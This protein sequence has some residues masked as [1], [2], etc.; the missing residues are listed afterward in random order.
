MRDHGESRLW[1][2]HLR[3]CLDATTPSY[4]SHTTAAAA[5]PGVADPD[6]LSRRWRK[7]PWAKQR[8]LFKSWAQPRASH[9][10]PGDLRLSWWLDLR[11]V[12]FGQ[13]ASWSDEYDD[14]SLHVVTITTYYQVW[15]SASGTCV[16][17]RESSCARGGTNDIIPV[18][19][20]VGAFAVAGLAVGAAKLLLWLW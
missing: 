1:C 5:S 8:E 2:G 3:A 15:L 20:A 9:S 19:L 11:S 7:L 17:R 18:V 13:Y 12:G 4:G 14:I 6:E 10:Y 16:Y